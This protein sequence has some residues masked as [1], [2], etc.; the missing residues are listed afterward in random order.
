MSG[1][2]IILEFDGA[3]KC[4]NGWRVFLEPLVR[5]DSRLSNLSSEMVAETIKQPTLDS[6]LKAG[7][8]L[9]HS[10]VQAGSQTRGRSRH[11]PVA[12]CGQRQVPHGTPNNSCTAGFFDSKD[13]KVNKTNCTN[14]LHLKRIR[15]RLKETREGGQQE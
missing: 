2:D 6:M 5:R 10:T 15:N 13:Q 12:G 8:Q 9:G 11:G 1:P 3:S 4:A 14:H 7:A